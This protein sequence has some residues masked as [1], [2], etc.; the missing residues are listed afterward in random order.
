[1]LGSAGIGVE[2]L[3]ISQAAE[4]TQ[5]REF[6]LRILLAGNAP[7]HELGDIYPTFS[8]FTL[9]HEDVRHLEFGSQFALR[10]MCLL[11]QATEQSRQIAIPYGMLRFGHAY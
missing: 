10:E 7:I 11:P 9:V 8:D 3:Q 5:A 2:K 1:L 4:S 6:L